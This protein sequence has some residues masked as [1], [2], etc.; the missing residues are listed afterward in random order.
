MFTLRGNPTSGWRGV[1]GRAGWGHLLQLGLVSTE[2]DKAGGGDIG[3]GL[4]TCG[5]KNV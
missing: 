4:C 1:L 5:K 2:V 3:L